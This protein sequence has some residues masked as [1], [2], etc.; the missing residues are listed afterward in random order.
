MPHY[1]V[2]YK[3]SKGKKHFEVQEASSAAEAKKLVKSRS[4][5][6][7]GMGGSYTT[8]KRILKAERVG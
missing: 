6:V 4:V 2:S 3:D 5:T 1:A 7:T 8:V